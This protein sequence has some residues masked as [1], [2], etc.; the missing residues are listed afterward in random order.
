MV[1]DFISQQ[2]ADSYTA[3]YVGKVLIRFLEDKDGPVESIKM[4]SLMP[5]IVSGDNLKSTPKH[6]PPDISRFS[7]KDIIHGPL[8]VKPLRE[9]LHIIYMS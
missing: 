7:L 2:E 5:K 6:L 1:W 3:E 8:D 4:E 9:R